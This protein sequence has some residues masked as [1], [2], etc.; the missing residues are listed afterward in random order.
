MSVIPASSQQLVT[1]LSQT[2]SPS[3][4]QEEQNVAEFTLSQKSAAEREG[5]LA[6][7]KFWTIKLENSNRVAD[8][9]KN[10][11]LFLNLSRSARLGLYTVKD[12]QIERAASVATALDR[13]RECDELVIGNA[14]E[15]ALVYDPTLTT[16]PVEVTLHIDPSAELISPTRVV[17]TS[18]GS[19]YL[20]DGYSIKYCINKAAIEHLTV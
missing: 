9:K 5:A 10:L 3:S 20:S 1:Q 2:L 4:S 6:L 8:L 13:I 19:Y 14:N 16:A 15:E 11:R 12:G 17:F 7:L 18:G